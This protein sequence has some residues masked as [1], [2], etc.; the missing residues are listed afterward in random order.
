MRKSVTQLLAPLKGHVAELERT[1]QRLKSE[2]AELQGV[3]AAEQDR[4][5]AVNA[6]IE[7]LE[8]A[9]AAFSR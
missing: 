3:L 9:A 1:D 7:E 4:W 5:T 6:Q 8:R 2:E